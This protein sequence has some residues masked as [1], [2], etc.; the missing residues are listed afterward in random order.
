M[1]HDE[2]ENNRITA[3][4]LLNNLAVNFGKELC[5]NFVAFE[6]MCMADDDNPKVRKNTVQNFVMICETVSPD[7][8]NNK[9]LSIYEKLAKDKHWQ[10]REEAVKIISKISTICLEETRETLLVNLYK[11]FCSDGSQFV[12][13]KAQMQIGQLIYSL[14]R[15]KI[16]P[17][18]IQLYISSV[19]KKDTD[20]DLVYHCAYTFPAVLYSLGKDIWPSIKDVYKAMVA[21]DFTGIKQT[22]AASIHEV[23]KIVGPE[24]AMKD[25]DPILKTFLDP[26]PILKNPLDV[27]KKSTLKHCFAHLHEFLEVLEESQ[28]VPYLDLV[29]NIIE[30]FERNWRLRQIFA[31]NAESYSKLYNAQL[32]HEKILPIVFNLLEDNV[33]EVRTKMSGPIYQI[34]M[35]I[36]SEPKY[37]E[38]MMIKID[39]YCSSRSFRDRQT[40]LHICSGFMCNESMFEQYLLTGFLALQKDKVPNVRVTLAKVLEEHMKCSGLLAKNTYI[41]KVLEMLQSDSAAEVINYVTTAILECDK[42]REFEES[43][44]TSGEEAKDSALKE[45]EQAKLKEMEDARMKE[46]EKARAEAEKGVD[47]TGV[48]EEEIEELNRRKAEQYFSKGVIVDEMVNNPS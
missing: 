47:I 45:E 46:I 18:L 17:F 24:I 39:K 11:E 27:N 35:M 38:E 6:L 16:D 31:L 7:F 36:K 33:M 10:V 44:V 9:L 20:E 15:S 37:F 1:A 40:F 48:D 41:V 14:R 26:I 32:V 23:A 13:R 22:L 4:K 43:G 21:K 34:A 30:S 3:I 25:L 29:A 12:R 42:M 5:E 28:R 8:F 19:P 2:N